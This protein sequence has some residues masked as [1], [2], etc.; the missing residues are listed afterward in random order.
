MASFAPLKLNKATEETNYSSKH[1]TAAE[2]DIMIKEGTFSIVLGSCKF[3][4]KVSIIIM[5]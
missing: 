2:K 4:N 3:F 1:I 5:W